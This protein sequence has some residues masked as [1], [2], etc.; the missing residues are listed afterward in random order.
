MDLAARNS[1]WFCAHLASHPVARAAIDAAYQDGFAAFRKE[2]DRRWCIAL[3]VAAEL[4]SLAAS[5]TRH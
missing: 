3:F 1:R 4:G 2:F 5:P